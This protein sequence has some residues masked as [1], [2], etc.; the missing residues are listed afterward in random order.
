MR[1]L[2]LAAVAARL[3]RELGGDLDWVA[4][5]QH[6]AFVQPRGAASSIP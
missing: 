3:H 4:V 2:R 6:G 5:V 1:P